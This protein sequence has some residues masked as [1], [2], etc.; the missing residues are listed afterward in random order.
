MLTNLSQYCNIL[1]YTLSHF[2][3]FIYLPNLGQE[4][5]VSAPPPFYNY[6]GVIMNKKTGLYI[7]IPFC[8]SKCPYCDFYS[9]KSNDDEVETYTQRLLELITYWGKKAEGRVITSVY[10]G[11]GTPNTLGSERL[12]KILKAV[13]SVFNVD[14]NA[15]I[16]TELNPNCSQHF[17][18]KNLKESGFNRLSFGM[19]SANKKELKILGRSHTPDD[20]K[21]V[22]KKARE[23]GFGN[24]SLDLMLGIPLQTKETLAKSI[25]FCK[26]CDV[27]HISA[28]ILKV[29]ENTPF[30][31]KKDCLRI[32][33]DDTQ[34]ELYS[35][36][37][38]K[39]EALG[40]YQYEISNFAKKGFES[41]HNLT[42]WECDEYIGIGPG[43][44]S[45]FD[46][47]RFHYPRSFDKFYDNNIIQDGSGGD[48]EEYI[49]LNLRLN[50]G[51]SFE[52]YKERFD[53]DFPDVTK[54]KAQK[55][56]DIGLLT[57]DSK[58]IRLNANGFLVSNSIISDLM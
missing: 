10:F 16:T 15:E 6:S 48:E 30:Y 53:A 22:I 11:G 7:H 8:K 21:S 38:K 24:I 35:F 42:Y 3:F 56:A 14:D 13:K 57:I 36:A 17:D 9:K 46:G 45:F 4:P 27:E 33:D 40:Y 43:A 39:L 12:C 52:R 54:N 25:D 55:Y 20:V 1:S 47:K 19:Q 50:K 34:A 41:R 32:P 58:G 2:L 51:I 18:F 37:V 29:E 23:S 49:M 44:Y 5:M 26:G 28:Y 31:K